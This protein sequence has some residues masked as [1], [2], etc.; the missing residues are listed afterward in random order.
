MDGDVSLEGY[1]GKNDT[2]E[3]SVWS[4][5]LK[6]VGDVANKGVGIYTALKGNKTAKPPAPAPA[7]IAPQSNWQ[8]YLPWAIGGVVLIVV[9]GLV[10]KRGR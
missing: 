10:F 7:A 4:G 3:D 1:T 9:L 8:Q 6:D 2:S 5:L